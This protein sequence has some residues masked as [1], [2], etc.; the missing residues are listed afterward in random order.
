MSKRAAALSPV[1]FAKERRL[2]E[3]FTA[4]LRVQGALHK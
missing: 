4:G 1:S 2:R 3:A